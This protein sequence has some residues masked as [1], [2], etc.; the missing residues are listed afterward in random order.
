MALFSCCFFP[1]VYM[2]FLHL[3]LIWLMQTSA[4]KGCLHSL[5]VLGTDVSIVD[6]ARVYSLRE[7]LWCGFAI[8]TIA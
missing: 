6:L 4:E 5:C 2:C 7:R 1:I 8:T 3:L